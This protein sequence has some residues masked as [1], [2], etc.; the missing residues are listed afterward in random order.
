VKPA[1]TLSKAKARKRPVF[2][3][4]LA[5]LRDG[6]ADIAWSLGLYVREVNLVGCDGAPCSPG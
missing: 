5:P 6:D 2:S 3:A 1:A 4:A